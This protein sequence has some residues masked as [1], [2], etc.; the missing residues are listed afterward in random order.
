MSE[1]GPTEEVDAAGDVDVDGLRVVRV[2]KRGNNGG[3]ADK[4]AVVRC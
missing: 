3:R 4:T 2:I 1:E